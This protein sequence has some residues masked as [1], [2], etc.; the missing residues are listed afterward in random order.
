MV[1][2]VC[3]GPSDIW[4][5]VWCILSVEEE[6]RDPPVKTAPRRLVACIRS[7][8]VG[9][10]QQVFHLGASYAVRSV[11]PIGHHQRHVVG[12][13]GVRDVHKLIPLRKVMEACFCTPPVTPLVP[14]SL[15]W[16][17][18]YQSQ[19]PGHHRPTL[20]RVIVHVS[21]RVV[22]C[23][24]DVLGHY[25][26]CF[27]LVCPQEGVRKSSV[28]FIQ[29]YCQRQVIDDVDFLDPTGYVGTSTPV[30]QGW[31]VP[32]QVIGILDIM[33]SECLTV[34]PLD[35]F[36]DVDGVF[37]EVIVS[38]PACR[39]PGY[40]FTLYEVDVKELRKGKMESRTKLISEDE[41]VHVV[42]IVKYATTGDAN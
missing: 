41:R 12:G 13:V 2:C 31:V 21:S 16:A 1:Y 35:S 14:D 3:Y 42:D 39:R 36:T 40:D 10:S 17:V 26:R 23:R 34:A 20:G 32:Q 7:Y 8:V 29:N 6:T 37:G 18:F 5:V 30:C 28:G 19:R 15:L 24:P 22:H 9:T 4:V 11:C 38:R 25:I 27:P 33:G